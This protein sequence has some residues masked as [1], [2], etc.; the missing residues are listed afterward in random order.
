MAAPTNAAKREKSSCQHG[1][2]HTWH[3]AANRDVRDPVATG[4]NPDMAPTNLVE[5]DPE[6][7]SDPR[8]QLPSGRLP[9][10]TCK[11]D[12]ALGGWRSHGR[13]RH[14]RRWSHHARDRRPDRSVSR[15]E[16]SSRC[17]GVFQRSVVMSIPPQNA[18]VSS[19]TT[20]LSAQAQQRKLTR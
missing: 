6:R 20:I 1:A 3:K 18:S 9:A 4:G 11:W 13:H 16:L 15:S 10:P 7:T 17:S 8:T 12:L 5:I 2:V 14:Q 19:T